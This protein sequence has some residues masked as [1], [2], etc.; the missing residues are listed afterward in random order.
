MDRVYCRP[1][2][3]FLMKMSL[4]GL[5][6]AIQNPRGTTGLNDCRHLSQRIRSHESSTHHAEACIMYEQWRNKG[7]IEEALHKSLLEKTNFWQNV[8]ERLGNVTLMLATCN[9]PFRG[10]SE[11]LSKDN[12]GNFL[13]IIQLF[14]K[15]DTV[16]DKLLQ[17]P[18]GSPKYLSSLIQHELISVLVEEVFRY[19]FLYLYLFIF[20]LHSRESE[21]YRYILDGTSALAWELPFFEVSGP[22]VFH[23]KAE[24][25][26]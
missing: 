14:A 6:N 20:I 13:S 7:T 24:A 21:L 15:Y 16:L 25:S 22:P 3:Y 23:I 5:L 17:L 18:E 2:G 26:R 4:Q 11:E 9:L 8:L 10:P 1:A 19:I 12:K